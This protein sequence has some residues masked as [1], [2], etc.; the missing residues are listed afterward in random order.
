MTPA[1]TG[2]HPTESLLGAAGP[3][4]TVVNSAGVN[5]ELPSR[6]RLQPSAQGLVFDTYLS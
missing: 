1:E 2:L 4:D 3:L 6:T 5:V